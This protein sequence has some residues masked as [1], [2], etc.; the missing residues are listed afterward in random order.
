MSCRP[1]GS[2]STI[3]AARRQRGSCGSGTKVAESS[4]QLQHHQADQQLGALLGVARVEQ[5]QDRLVEQRRYPHHEFLRQPL[6]ALLAL[7]PGQVEISVRI[8]M[9]ASRSMACS[10]RRHPDGAVRRHQ[11]A[12]GVVT[13]IVAPGR[14]RSAAPRG[15]CADRSACPWDSR[16]D[17]VH[18][19]G[20]SDGCSGPPGGWAFPAVIGS[21][22]SWVRHIT[23]FGAG[24]GF[25]NEQPQPGDQF[26]QRRPFHRPLCDAD[27]RRRRNHHGAG[28]RHGL[29]GTSALCDAGL[30]RLRRGLAAHRLARGPLE[31]P[32]HDADLLRRHRCFH[33]LGRLRADPGYSLA[34]RCS[35]SA[36]LLRSITPSAPR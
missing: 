25:G 11:P 29:F 23:H 17:Q 7:E 34:R 21:I 33:D 9:S 18:A 26:R 10:S 19:R 27:F 20:R 4:R 3:I 30:R 35:R 32:P 14:D 2:S 8:S 12:P 13:C 28:A 36:F 1:V 6:I 22:P 24:R 16:G 31:P 5:R 15:A